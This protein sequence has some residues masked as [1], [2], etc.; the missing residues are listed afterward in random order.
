V[1]LNRE[2]DWQA[3]AE[4][5]FLLYR[6]MAEHLNA[7]LAAISL[8]DPSN[9]KTGQPAQFWQQR[10]LN[11]TLNALNLHNAWS[12]LI[13]HKAG[14]TMMPQHQR[15]FQANDLL[16]WLARELQLMYT[17]Q[18]SQDITLS[19]NRETLQEALLLLRSSAQMLG[20]G[21]HLQAQATHDGLWFRVRYRWYKSPPANLGAL[22]ESLGKHW[23][24]RGTAFEL[25]RAQDF[26]AMNDC[27]LVYQVV[28][29]YCELAFFIYALGK[30]PMTA[31]TPRSNL[32]VNRPLMLSDED[33]VSTLIF[34][35]AEP[36]TVVKTPR[37]G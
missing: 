17:P 29:D 26:L 8:T 33:S 24:G 3:L 18:A 23:R 37:S 15:R 9:S 19:G 5:N 22:L 12:S 36:S 35:S 32:E 13:R 11:E 34:G 10:A 16:R 4:I 28:D 6:R 21:V 7:A 30:K 25:L 2:P 27:P 31:R 1:I 14:E 20:P